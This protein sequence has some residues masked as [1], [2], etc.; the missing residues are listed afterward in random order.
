MSDPV[1]IAGVIGTWV[2]VFFA[3][4][5]LVGIVGPLLL[6][7]QTRSERFQA[8]AAIDSPEYITKGFTP[9]KGYSFFRK[10]KVPTLEDPPNPGIQPQTE[11]FAI[12]HSDTKN[13]MVAQTTSSSTGWV[14][15][16]STLEL[17]KRDFEKGDNLVFRGKQAWLPVHRFWLLAFG[18]RGRFGHRRDKGKATSSGNAARLR[19]E[20]H[21]AVDRDA[22]YELGYLQGRLYGFTGTLWWKTS[23]S[24][25]SDPDEVYFALHPKEDRQPS[26]I[27]D[28][29]PLSTL[30]W[31]SLGCLPLVGDPSGRVFD[32][33]G[34]LSANQRA[35]N[36]EEEI[37]RRQQPRK[38]YR[39]SKRHDFKGYRTLSDRTTTGLTERT[40][41]HSFA[42]Y[43]TPTGNPGDGAS[44]Q[45]AD[46]MG[47]NMGQI[48][49]MNRCHKPKESKAELERGLWWSV[50]DVSQDFS[51]YVWRSDI[52]LQALALLHLPLSPVGFLFDHKRTSGKAGSEDANCKVFEGSWRRLYYLQRQMEDS[53][54]AA[55]LGKEERE[56]IG[57][58]WSCWPNE[59]AVHAGPAFGRNRTRVGFE[60]DTQI[61]SNR[62]TL[63][64]GIQDVIGIL[65]MTTNTHLSVRTADSIQKEG[66]LRTTGNGFLDLLIHG[67]SKTEIAQS[68]VLQVDVAANN[69]K[70][71]SST[72]KDL[73]TSMIFEEVFTDA[74][75][76]ADISGRYQNFTEFVLLA[77]KALFR[78]VMFETAVDSY[79]LLNLVE[80][81]ADVVNVSAKS[82]PPPLEGPVFSHH[83][84]DEESVHRYDSSGSSES[85]PSSQESVHKP[86]VE[87][88]QE[89]DYGGQ[90][91]EKFQ[92]QLELAEQ[93]RDLQYEFNSLQIDSIRYDEP[94]RTSETRLKKPSKEG[95][96]VVSEPKSGEFIVDIDSVGPVEK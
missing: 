21:Q 15:F 68:C 82:Q 67:M 30:F 64:M 41:S 59:A 5:A 3:I 4:L 96:D 83:E 86:A 10:G 74:K 9:R 39:F 37:H 79:P 31:L 69:V 76:Y 51:D 36:E 38:F 52:Q 95:V 28:Q 45:W 26:L 43:E 57:R 65:T 49:C 42:T 35:H 94:N 84:P 19:I 78:G 63:P 53:D 87:S 8:L 90:S 20:G 62:K 47:I 25:V 22:A 16:A 88:S 13:G 24:N 93:I 54:F 11:F 80:K 89:G 66:A 81:M 18:L 34:F 85:E 29:M 1:N 12:L 72:Y 17:Y 23:G 92:R 46:A 44:K 27:P 48:W 56:A 71:S 75:S 77:L 2:A 7:Y 61:L 60:L 55:N 91:V 6:I 14:N 70:L 40:N 50:P 58:L 32:L 33:A 73:E